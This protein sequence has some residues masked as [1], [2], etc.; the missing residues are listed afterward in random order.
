MLI[1]KGKKEA[2]PGERTEKT[3]RVLRGRYFQVGNV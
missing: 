2:K 3:R 1:K